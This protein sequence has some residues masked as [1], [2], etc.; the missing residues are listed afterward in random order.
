[1]RRFSATVVYLI[2]LVQAGAAEGRDVD[3]KLP[4]ALQAGETAF[5]EVQLGLLPRGK[6]IEVTTPSGRMLGVISPFGLRAGQEAGT[7]NLP[8]PADTIIDG[9]VIIRLYV[10]QNGTRRTPSVDEVRNVRVKI[11]PAAR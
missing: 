7:Y 4:R 10:T 3:L 1:V 8:L 2:F 9:H 6:E 11:A 5:I